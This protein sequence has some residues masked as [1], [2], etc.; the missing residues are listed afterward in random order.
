MIVY[1]YRNNN[2]AYNKINDAIGKLS[3]SF[4]SNCEMCIKS[5]VEPVFIMDDSVKVNFQ[6]TMNYWKLDEISKLKDDWNK[7]GAKGFSEEIIDNMKKILL[8]LYFQPEIYP[9]ANESIQFEYENN[10]GDYLEFELFE[11]SKVKAFFYDRDNKSWT[12]YIDIG[13]INGEV[14]KFIRL[15]F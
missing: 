6:L 7:N 8:D 13:E 12:K 3:Q 14:E 15:D 11:D 2:L 10:R 4:L 5:V 9:T 1:T